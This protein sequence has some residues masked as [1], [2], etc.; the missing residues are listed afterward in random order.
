MKVS[1]FTL[2]GLTQLHNKSNN[3][4]LSRTYFTFIRVFKVLDFKFRIFIYKIIL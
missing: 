3:L 2:N 4:V 1:Y